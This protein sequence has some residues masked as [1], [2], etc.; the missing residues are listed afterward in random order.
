MSATSNHEVAT[1]VAITRH[2]LGD[3]PV[4]EVG[5][6]L[7]LWTAPELCARIEECL[8]AS[9]QGVV[10]D[11]SLHRHDEARECTARLTPLAEQHGMSHHLH[12]LRRSLTH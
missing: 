9:E 7:D 11:G 10:I 4:L 1:R 6:E 12:L 3:V 8:E 2:Q 5:G